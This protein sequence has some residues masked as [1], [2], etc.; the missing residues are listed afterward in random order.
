MA[1][2]FFSAIFPIPASV[3]QNNLLMDVSK[4]RA[5]RVLEAGLKSKKAR[6]LEY[7]F[8]NGGGSYGSTDCRVL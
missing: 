5:L 7:F 8:G 6:L 3:W 2:I 1:Q 4:K